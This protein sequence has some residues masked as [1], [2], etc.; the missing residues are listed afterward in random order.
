MIPGG[1]GAVKHAVTVLRWDLVEE[2]PQGL[3][4]LALVT[5]LSNRDSTGAGA[6]VEGAIL[7]TCVIQVAGLGG[8]QA[9]VVFRKGRLTYAGR[10]LEGEL[11][12]LLADFTDASAVN[13]KEHLLRVGQL[14][15]F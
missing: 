5:H 12:T 6:D 9:V 3:V 13:V 15:T 1:A 8:V 14:S 4:A 10:G 7:L 11:R 2:L